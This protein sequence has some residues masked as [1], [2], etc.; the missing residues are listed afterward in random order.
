M[1]PKAKAKSAASSAPDRDE[2]VAKAENLVRECLAETEIARV[3]GRV[4]DI[5]VSEARLLAGVDP[6]LLAR[7]E[8]RLAEYRAFEEE[9]QRRA[10]E[11]RAR[12]A[13]VIGQ[14]DEENEAFANAFEARKRLKKQVEDLF[15]A[16]G[17][18][19]LDKVQA[20][21]REHCASGA[22]TEPFGLPPLA[23]DVEDHDG[24]TPLSEA[25]CYGETEIVEFLLQ[26]GAHPNSRN[27]QGRTPLWRATY[28]GHEDIVKLLLENGADPSI[29]NH[30]GEPPGKY[31]TD[32][33]KALIAGWDRTLTAE[34]QEDLRPLQRLEYPWPH[35]LLKACVA[36]DVKAA[37][38]IVKAI[39]AE[40]AGKA[41]PLL[42]T[43][44]NFEDMADSVWMAC[45]KGHLELAAA[46]LDAGADLDSSTES[47]LTCLMIACRKGHREVVKELLKRG[48]KT[49][50]RS[51]QG[52]LASDYAREYGDGHQVHD[53]VVSHCRQ[54]QDWTT[55]E[56]EARQ[57]GGNK[58]CGVEAVERLLDSRKNAGASDAATAALKAMSADELREGGDRYRQ[59]LEERALADVLGMG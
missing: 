46:L 19:E 39:A 58:A 44:L 13:E 37:S 33:T 57:A 15:E 52:R 27:R 7:G 43:V 8:A 45:T 29:E 42:R 14:Q 50:L 53:L 22:D 24:N 17:D 48:A 35:L 9:L 3:D 23:V 25:S 5:A 26:S 6:E 32:G 49:H 59:L 40:A 51:E 30:D 28:N 1:P 11:L 54:S 36:G 21:V 18:S 56:E 55:L 2:K 16:V 12:K 10:E 31:G 20:F 4:L 47:G 41:G 38:D 34:R